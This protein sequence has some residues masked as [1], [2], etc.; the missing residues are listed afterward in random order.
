MAIGSKHASRSAT[1]A[2]R[3]CTSG[4]SSTNR[5]MGRCFLA[6]FNYYKSRRLFLSDCGSRTL[7]DCRQSSCRRYLIA[8]S[9]HVMNVD[10]A[11]QGPVEGAAVLARKLM[12]LVGRNGHMHPSAHGL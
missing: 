1:F 3:I 7:A 11:I 12:L 10:W 9:I 6:C 4:F 5:G 2:F 8:C